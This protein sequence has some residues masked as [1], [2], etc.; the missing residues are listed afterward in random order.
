VSPKLS[1]RTKRFAV[2][3][4]RFCTSLPRS[5]EGDIIKRQL[6][7]SACSVGANYRAAFRGRSPAEFVAKLGI[8]EEECDETLY[9]L[10]LIEE[11]DMPCGEKLQNLKSE[12]DQLLAILVTSKK[13]SRANAALR[14]SNVAV[15]TSNE[16]H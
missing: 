10:E 14:T 7:R 15:R 9:W 3:V 16:Q 12:A 13:T 8:A 6:I 2:D 5:V 1:Q 11:A 4:I